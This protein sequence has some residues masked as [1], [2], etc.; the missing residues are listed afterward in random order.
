M[1]NLVKVYVGT[2]Y[3]WYTYNETKLTCLKKTHS[4]HQINST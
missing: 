3:E 1:S 4:S 2:Y